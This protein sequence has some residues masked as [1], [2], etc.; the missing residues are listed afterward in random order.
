[1]TDISSLQRPVSRID[2]ILPKLK[3]IWHYYPELSMAELVLTV[4]LAANRVKS[5][6]PQTNMFDIEDIAYPE[7]HICHQARNLEMGIEELEKRYEGQPLPPVPI[8]TALL[9]KVAD[10][11]RNQ[12]QMRLGQLLSNVNLLAELD[13]NNFTTH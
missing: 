6:L 9:G 7:G 1:M 13:A 12:P 11:W 2:Y 4:T 3:Y 5:D 10:S 8:Q